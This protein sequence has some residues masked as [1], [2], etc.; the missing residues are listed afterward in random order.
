MYTDRST[1]GSTLACNLYLAVRT[2][3]RLSGPILASHTRGLGSARLP[4]GPPTHPPHQLHYR[5]YITNPHM[6]YQVNGIRRIRHEFIC[7]QTGH[8][9][10][11]P[12][13]HALCPPLSPLP[14]CGCAGAPKGVSSAPRPTSTHT[15]TE[16]KVQARWPRWSVC[17]TT[18]SWPH[19]V[20]HLRQ[21]LQTSSAT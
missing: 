8:S 11:W 9:T 3:S 16:I 10:P 7:A 13:T 1:Q 4:T 14:C 15:W 17:V 12:S 2:R 18:E 20:L 6:R 5:I 19:A 21:L